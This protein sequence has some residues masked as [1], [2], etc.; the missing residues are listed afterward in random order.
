MRFDVPT[1]GRGTLETLVASG[2][3]VLAIE[4]AKTIIIDQDEVV[5]FARQHGVSLVAVDE[6]GLEEYRDAA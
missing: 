4:A 2:G 3:R 5:R 1:I 6:Q